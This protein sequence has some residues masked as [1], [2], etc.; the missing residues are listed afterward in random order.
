M[1]N[2][3]RIKRDE[4][5]CRVMPMA[6]LC[7]KAK[8]KQESGKA[9]FEEL[10]SALERG[11]LVNITGFGRFWIQHTQPRTINLPTGPGLT[12]TREIH[13]PGNRRVR[14]RMGS[15]LMNGLKVRG[16]G[17]GKGTE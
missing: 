4:M 2:A 3:K 6:T 5:P 9:F 16:H 13:S 8:I 7:R 14:Y 11:Y 17:R 15:A 1:S 10:V 12:G